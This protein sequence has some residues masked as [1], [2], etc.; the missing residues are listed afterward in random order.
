[1]HRGNSVAGGVRVC[2]RDRVRVNRGGERE[3][4]R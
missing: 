1:M 4:E 2:F 3:R